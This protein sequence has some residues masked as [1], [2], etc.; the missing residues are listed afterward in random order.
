MKLRIFSLAVLI[1]GLMAA[2]SSSKVRTAKADLVNAQGESVGSATFKSAASGVMITLSVKNLPPGV[3]ALHIHA[4][5]KCD[6]PDFSSA[7]PHFNPYHKM[8][9]TKNTEGPHAGDLPNITV[10]PDGTARARVWAH[11]VT[12][13]T[14][15]NSLL[16]PAG[17]ALVIHASPDDEVTDPAGNAG[18]RIA[19]GV[20][21]TE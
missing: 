1:V 15:V 6:P 9:G 14:G 17:T 19:C 2:C 12:L 18:A 8:H 13:G 21:K 5:G 10:G 11:Q 20:I 3:H 4:V 16:Q 7:G